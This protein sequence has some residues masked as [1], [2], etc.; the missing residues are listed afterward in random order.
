MYY[1][2]ILS[3][4]GDAECTIEDKKTT[5]VSSEIDKLMGLCVPK[6]FCIDREGTGVVTSRTVVSE[7]FMRMYLLGSSDHLYVDSLGAGRIFTEV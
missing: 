6:R 3:N 5:D 7:Q 4:C 2:A 1:C